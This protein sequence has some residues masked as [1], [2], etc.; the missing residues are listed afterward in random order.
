MKVIS[1]YQPWAHWVSVSV[2]SIETRLHNRFKSLVGGEI[3]IHAC[4]KYDNLA[5]NTAKNFTRYYLLDHEK[6][7]LIYGAIICTAFV[8]KVGWLKSSHSKKACINCDNTNRFGLFLDNVK[9]LK[10]PIFGVGRQGIFH[11]D[12]DTSCNYSRVNIYDGILAEQLSMD[13]K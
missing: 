10:K 2:K 6:D 11:F 5:Y 8:R 9:L 13:L 12:I 1:L 7:Q 4:K 3:A